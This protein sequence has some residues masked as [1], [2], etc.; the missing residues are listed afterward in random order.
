MKKGASEDRSDVPTKRVER[1]DLFQFRKLW[2]WCR[3]DGCC[4]FGLCQEPVVEDVSRYKWNGESLLVSSEELV[5]ERPEL[6]R[7]Y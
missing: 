3:R 1:P 7:R 5:P 4:W 6:F 2:G